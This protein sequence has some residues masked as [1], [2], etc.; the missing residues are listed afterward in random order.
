MWNLEIVWEIS[1]RDLQK[2]NSHSVEHKLELQ[3]PQTHVTGV[4]KDLIHRA[5]VICDLKKDIF[6]ELDLLKNIFV[7]N[8]DPEHLVMKTF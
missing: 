8:G 2:T 7:R 4:L 6:E 5:H 3:S 1:H